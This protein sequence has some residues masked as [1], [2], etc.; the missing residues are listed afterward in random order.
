M[1]DI[2][3]RIEA[4]LKQRGTVLVNW[5]HKYFTEKYVNQLESLLRAVADI[6]EHARKEHGI[7][8]T[9]DLDCEQCKRLA[10]F[11]AELERAWK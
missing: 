3:T 7:G 1:T 10:A 6:I 5:E 11:S 8:H 2:R 9:A 4:L